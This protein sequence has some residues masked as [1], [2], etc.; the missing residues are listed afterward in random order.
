MSHNSTTRPTLRSPY[1][2]IT[3]AAAGAAAGLTLSLQSRP[4]PGTVPLTV[5]D[6]VDAVCL[7]LF[8]FL[9]AA[10]LV[11][12]RAEG[13]ARALLL[14]GTFIALDYLLHGVGDALARG[15]SPPSAA[16]RLCNLGGEAAFIATFLLLV[17]APLSLFPTGRLPSRRWQPLGWVCGLGL[18]VSVL[19]LL[20]NP[21]PVDADVP[22]WGDNPIGLES[23]PRVPDALE[24]AGGVLLAITLLGGLSAFV[25]RWIRYRGVRRRQM[26]WLT[27]GATTMLVGI[28]VDVGGSELF[29]VLLALAIFGTLLAGMAWPL[30]GPL[31]RA[32]EHEPA[33]DAPPPAGTRPGRGGPV[34]AL[35]GTRRETASPTPPP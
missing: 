24:L 8:G 5:E 20:L 35:R 22:A 3:L 32:A 9:G 4:V 11:R 23:L 10:L 6:F 7:L 26:T 14:I 13:L 15:G 21:G 17:F 25:S 16:A 27:L 19:A 30:L 34:Q 2:W 1:A 28:T 33:A 29:Q 31:G 12:R 18:L